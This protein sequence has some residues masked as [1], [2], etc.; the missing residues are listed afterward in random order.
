MTAR[1][2]PLIEQYGYL[3]VLF[4]VMLESIGIPIPGETILIVAGFLVH[5]GTL[6]LTT[7]IVLGIFAT[8]LGNQIGYWAG[9]KGG[10]P[11]VVRWGYYVGITPE[12]LA[13]VEGFFV[14]HGGKS[15]FLARFVP[16]LRAFGALVAGIGHMHRRSF[17]FYNILAGAVWATASVIGGYLFGKSLGLLETWIGPGSVLLVIVLIFLI[18][19]FYLA[20]RF[21]GKDK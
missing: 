12:R 15:V 14:R 10:R 18:L 6:N 1:I 19:V 5:Q 2:L 8:I 20:Y 17:F 21:R 11:F 13:R 16:W 9:L 7:T 4:G 3:V